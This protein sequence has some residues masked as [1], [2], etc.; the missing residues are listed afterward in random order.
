EDAESDTSAIQLPGAAAGD[1]R[2]MH[3]RPKHIQR[4]EHRRV[5]ASRP[6][7]LRAPGACLL[8]PHLMR[9]PKEDLL[10]AHCTAYPADPDRP[11]RWKLVFTCS[12]V[13]AG[14]AHR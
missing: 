10:A 1:Q 14:S 8:V 4:Q 12:V 3:R 9:E 13:I 7:D 2:E 6:A 11:V 5:E